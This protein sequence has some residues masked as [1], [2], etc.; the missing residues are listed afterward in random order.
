MSI[1]KN[2]TSK[3]LSRFGLKLIRLRDLQN[4]VLQFQETFEGSDA[5]DACWKRSMQ[6]RDSLYNLWEVG[7]YLHANQIEG[8]FVE[9]GVWRGASMQLL[10]RQIV[11]KNL[12]AKSMWLYDTFGGMTQPTQADKRI[13]DGRLAEEL[14]WDASELQEDIAFMSGV[15]AFATLNDVKDGFIQMGLDLQ[16]LNFIIGDVIET[17][18]RD[19]PKKISLLRIDTDWYE[20]TSHILLN[21]YPRVVTGGVVI[22]DDYDYWS[23]ARQAADEYFSSHQLHP[24]LLRQTGGGRVFIKN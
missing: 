4:S 18:P 5:L 13:K 11:E 20:S 1:A 7:S 15:H 14:G 22:L 8:D 6:T 12:S 17:I 23:G 3:V 2:L 16:N 10:A 9:C 21:L 19:M 24:L